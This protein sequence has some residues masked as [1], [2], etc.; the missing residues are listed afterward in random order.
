MSR[1]FGPLLRRLLPALAVLLSGALPAAAQDGSTAPDT[2]RSADV[3]AFPSPPL[4]EFE[5]RAEEP[6]GKSV[7]DTL[8]A[9]P[10]TAADTD[11]G[12]APDSVARD[13]VPDSTW[14]WPVDA[15]LAPCADGAR[16]VES[17]GQCT[18]TSP[19][20]ALKET[21]F[22]GVRAA[23][24]NLR[25]LEPARAE[26]HYQLALPQSPYGTGG[27]LPF[28]HLESDGARGVETEGWVPVQPLDTPVTDLHW[29]RGALLMNQF[30]ITL[31]RMVGN[32]AY[33][34]L[35]YGSNSAVSQFYDYAFQVHQPYLGGGRD[36]LSLVIADTSHSI[37]SRHMRGRLGFWLDPR[38]VFEAHGD[39]L[40]NSTS[41]AN[42]TNQDRND[43]A[44]LLYPA[45]F[46]AAT[47]GALIA[48]AD[49]GRLLRAGV[50]H[51]TWTR[52]LTP[53]GESPR[54]EIASGRVSALDARAALP[55]LPGAPRLTLAAEF[56]AQNGALWTRGALPS[57]VPTDDARGDRETATLEARPVVP[58]P[59]PEARVELDLRGNAARRARPDGVTEALGGADA[60]ARLR[61]PYGF[62][63]GGGAGWNREGA[64]DD[65]L[66]RWQPALGLYPN[67]GLTPR[68]HARRG[69]GAGWESRHAGFGAEWERHRFENNWLPRVLPEPF[70]CARLSDTAAYAGVANTCAG[71]PYGTSIPDSVALA[72]VNYAEETRDLLHLSAYLAA[73]NWRLSVRS[74]YLLDNLVRD[75]A[76]LGFEGANHELPEAVVK[77]RLQWR[78]RVLDGRL[79]LQTRWDWEWFSPRYVFASDMDGTARVVPLDEYLALDF[80]AQMEIKTFLLYFRAMNLYHDRYATEPG[81]H[82]PGVNF[83]FGVDWRLR[84]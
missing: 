42:P 12:A 69:A 22:P 66:F 48:R 56:S 36:S 57:S 4:P 8:A 51:A 65:L 9:A 70:V 63:L 3:E 81:V 38:T 29:M 44:Q 83:R 59:L 41:M 58:L 43:S 33:F 71:G 79:G 39:W 60:D 18:R 53:R 26:A 25:G 20:R 10:K 84:N 47:Y 64:P 74:T 72:R 46:E 30:V 17:T 67:P 54:P 80:T 14:R 37:S 77:G 52:D 2:G 32:R 40:S 34:G 50:R 82:P 76:R 28:A 49:E 1:P 24:M 11:T 68:T 19:D 55:G 31:H 45:S 21:G 23:T 7:A 6:A 35:D 27:H 16:G 73:G 62:W 13:P 61:L 78:R 5:E 15:R 75:P